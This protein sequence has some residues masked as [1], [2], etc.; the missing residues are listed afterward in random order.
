[1]IQQKFS[2]GVVQTQEGHLIDSVFTQPVVREMQG[3]QAGPQV[4]EHVSRDALDLV[5]MQGELP[6]ARRQERGHVNQL[7]VGEI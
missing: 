7:V 5:V 4:A 3:I 1:M 6:Q 2:Q